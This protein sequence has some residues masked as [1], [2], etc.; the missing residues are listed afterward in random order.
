MAVNVAPEENPVFL[1]RDAE[2]R[3]AYETAVRHWRQAADKNPGNLNLVRR[4]ISAL[5][6]SGR[7]DETEAAALEAGCR[8]PDDVGIALELGWIAARRKDWA[9]ALCRWQEVDAK[10]PG[11]PAVANVPG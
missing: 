3:R 11:H 5:E 7:A 8:F 2:A 6:K 10:L 1:A 4:L 9:L